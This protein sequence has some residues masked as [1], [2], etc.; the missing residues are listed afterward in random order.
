MEVH[1]TRESVFQAEISYMPHGI[2]LPHPLDPRFE[3]YSILGVD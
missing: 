3:H 2:F 1:G